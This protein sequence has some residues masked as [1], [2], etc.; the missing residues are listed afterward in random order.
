M[1]TTEVRTPTRVP[2]VDIVETEEGLHLIADLPG[3]G[4]DRLEV[5]VDKGILA[6]AARPEAAPAGWSRVRSEMPA[7]EFRREFRVG[8]GLNAGRTRAS[9]RN[10]VLELFIPIAE[11]V[12]PHRI[13][14]RT[15]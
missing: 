5:T 3:V 9:L 10:G 12:K 11:V 4:E 14:V 1:N 2:F 8:E 6:I 7:G 15:Q 13:P